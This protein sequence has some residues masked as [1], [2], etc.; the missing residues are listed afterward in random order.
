MISI[1]GAPL[2]PRVISRRRDK[3]LEFLLQQTGNMI[4]ARA[5]WAA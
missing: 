4:W 3:G 5:A 2:T 1:R